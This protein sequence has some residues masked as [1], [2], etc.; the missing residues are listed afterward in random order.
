[1]RRPLLTILVSTVAGL[2]VIWYA[3]KSY[4]LGKGEVVNCLGFL[5][6]LAS[7]TLLYFQVKSSLLF[8]RRRTTHEFMHGPVVQTLLPLE[9]KLKQA[10]NRPTLIFERGVT[11]AS[12]RDDQNFDEVR[13][14]LI[15][16]LNFYERMAIALRSTVFDEDMLYDDRGAVLLSFHDWVHPLIAEFRKQHEPRAY[17]NMGAVVAHW[18]KR[19][20]K[21]AS[22]NRQIEA[23]QL[24]AIALPK[25]DLFT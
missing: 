4:Q 7:V 19:Y 24:E 3:Q 21:A 23:K 15:D 20:H 10:L 14:V 17:V 8:E 11:V 13:A 18:R 16:I 22:R 2:L 25:H 5:L 9:L 6:V 1:M 12:I